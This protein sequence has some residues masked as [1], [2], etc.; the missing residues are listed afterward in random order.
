MSILAEGQLAATQS[1]VFEV[2]TEAERATITQIVMHNI[3]TNK[4][5]IQGFAKKKFGTARSIGTFLLK[6]GE[7]GEYIEPGR[8]VNLDSGDTFEAFT[9][10]AA[11][12]DITIFGTLSSDVTVGGSIAT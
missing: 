12:V 6:K 9:T 8:P 1:I 11:S 3:G 5:T 4:E 2:P 7:R 10:N